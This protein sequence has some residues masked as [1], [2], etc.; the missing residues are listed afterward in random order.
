MLL[1]LKRKKQ[2]DIM[3]E[4]VVADIVSK[5]SDHRAHMLILRERNGLRRIVVA[6]GLPE[7]HAVIY[8]MRKLYMSRPMTYDLFASLTNAYGMELLYSL[9]NEVVNGTF[10]ARIFYK[11]GEVVK[12]I[13]ARPSDAVVLSL[14]AGAPIYITEELLDK[15]CIQDEQ[16]GAISMP[17]TV[18][19][20]ETL[21]QA[22]DKAVKAENYELAMILKGELDSRRGKSR[23]EKNNQNT[24]E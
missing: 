12:S 19:D 23:D 18:A 3:I 5:V 9:V 4:L 14:R 13:D 20:E 6:V 11:Q 2:I 24:K 16:N 7:A 1:C 21:L 22:M 17:I 10:R 15:M 8:A